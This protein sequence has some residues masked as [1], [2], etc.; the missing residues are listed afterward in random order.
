MENLYAIYLYAIFI[1]MTPLLIFV[2][3]SAFFCLFGRE[4]REN[5]IKKAFKDAM[6]ELY[7][8]TRR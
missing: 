3:L 6:K 2:S 7:E 4:I 8:E 5:I 1:F